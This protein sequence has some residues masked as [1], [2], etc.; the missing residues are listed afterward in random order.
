MYTWSKPNYINVDID[1]IVQQ[2]F[3][4]TCGYNITELLFSISENMELY[5]T[6]SR[7]AYL[8]VCCFIFIAGVPGNILIIWTILKSKQMRKIHNI[9]VVFLAVI[10]LLLTGY[11]IPFNMYVLITNVEP[12]RTFCKVQAMICDSLFIWSIQFI[13]LIAL[14]R[15]VK[16]CHGNIFDKIFQMKYIIIMLVLFFTLAFAFHLPLWYYDYLL[17]FDRTLQYCAFDRYGSKLYSY[18]YI[19]ICLVSPIGVTSFCYVRIYLHVRKTKNQLHKHWN[20][21]FA[22]RK[23]TS[24]VSSFKPQFVVFIAYLIL[25]FPFALTSVVGSNAT[26]FPEDFHS[27]GIYMCFLSSCI[28]IF[29]YGVMNKNMRKAYMDSL[30]CSTLR[31][32]NRV[33]PITTIATR[34]TEVAM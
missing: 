11:L 29:I 12:P 25:Y 9:F 1:V 2:L 7:I 20:N 32:H 5:S 28:N 17:I 24:E 18:I 3:F 33:T 31:R 34:S 16:I 26:D 4:V 21:G 22:Q 30:Q 15:Y 27:I 13:M 6:Q 19:A 14:S 23:L 8:T 10:D